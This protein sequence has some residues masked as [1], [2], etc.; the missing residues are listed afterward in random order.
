MRGNVCHGGGY[1]VVLGQRSQDHPQLDDTDN[2]V[3]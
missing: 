2:S 3:G 1:S